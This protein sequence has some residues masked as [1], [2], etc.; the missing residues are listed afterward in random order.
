MWKWL[1][2]TQYPMT[3]PTVS[4]YDQSDRQGE[5]IEILYRCFDFMWYFYEQRD[6]ERNSDHKGSR[7]RFQVL[8]WNK[9]KLRTRIVFLKPRN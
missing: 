7:E 2:N 9:N 8:S 5:A 1:D 4:E 3:S 6:A